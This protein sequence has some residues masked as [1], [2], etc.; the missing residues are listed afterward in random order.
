MR[1]ARLTVLA[2]AALTMSVALAGP[3]PAT[4]LT[5][6][7]NAAWLRKLPFADR[8]DFEDAKRGL[9]ARFPSRRSR[10]PTARRRDFSAY[11]FESAADAP[12]TV[13]RASGDWRN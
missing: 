12:P 4:P 10:A 1:I 2:S 13:N 7:S 3:N 11:A 6:Q 9:V 8:A 5:E